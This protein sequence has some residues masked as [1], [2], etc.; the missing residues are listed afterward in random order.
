MAVLSTEM[1]TLN[2]RQILCPEVSESCGLEC[3]ELHHPASLSSLRVLRLA[4]S[5]LPKLRVCPIALPVAPSVY[6][7]AS[8][9][10]CPL[11]DD[12]TIQKHGCQVAL[13]FYHF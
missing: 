1:K 7:P 6:L 11:M 13:F 2:P 12:R 4:L 9:A 8:G 3:S 5:Q 10:L